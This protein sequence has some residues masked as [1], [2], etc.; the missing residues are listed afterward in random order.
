MLMLMVQ[1][2]I[3]AKAEIPYYM[4]HLLRVEIISYSYL[5]PRDQYSSSKNLSNSVSLV[6]ILGTFYEIKIDLLLIIYV[7]LLFDNF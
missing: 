3:S 4:T 6:L 5:S 2:V 7:D 1:N